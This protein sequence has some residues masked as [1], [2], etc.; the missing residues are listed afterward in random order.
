MRKLHKAS[1]S[2]FVL[3][4]LGCGQEGTSPQ[5]ENGVLD[6][7]NY[8]WSAGP[9]SLKGVWRFYWKEFVDPQAQAPV[10]GFIIVPG[11]WNQFATP[12]GEAGGPGY[13]TYRLEVKLGQQPPPLSLRMLH[14]DS[15]CRIYVNGMLVEQI[16][17]PGKSANENIAE[18]K[19]GVIRLE[20]A[21]NLDIV[22]HVANFEHRNGGFPRD[23]LIGPTTQ[24]ENVRLRHLFRDLFLCGSLCMM[25]LYHFALF[26]LRP[27]D[28]AP[29]FFALFCTLIAIR[30][31]LVG[32]RV[33]SY[34]LF[35]SPSFPLLHRIEYLSFL[36]ATPCFFAYAASLF[37]GKVFR[38]WLL[39]TISA[40]FIAGSAVVI[41]T[42]SF[43]YTQ[44][45]FAFQIL[46]MAV[47]LYI[48]G[49]AVYLIHL[50]R[51]GARVFVGTFVVFFLSVINDVLYS[52]SVV[53]SGFFV[54]LGLFLFT[55][56][57]AFLLSRLY[58]ESF[59]RVEEL[60]IDLENSE[61]RYRHLVEDSGEIILSLDDNGI[62]LSSNQAATRILGYSL[63]D[64]NG[65]KLS[66]LIYDSGPS[67][68]FM[69]KRLFEERLVELVKNDK[70][71]E[72]PAHFRTTHSDVCELNVRLQRVTLENG[73]AIIANLAQ[74][75]MDI[76][77]RYCLED[78]RH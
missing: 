64:L 49:G 69:A 7:R 18:R 47:G 27:R 70:S 21:E 22:I 59:R 37:P 61:R 72:F 23:L 31:D 38:P 77:A 55:F 12:A 13:A 4:I 15:A 63:K 53:N 41:T 20:P 26:A 58:A 71:Q 14:F 9:L 5:A 78:H 67:N 48:M 1:L 19:P 51:P 34:L 11:K 25:A 33:I 54:A 57:Q 42:P 43:V 68:A 60:A 24:I 52:R 74:K 73:R 29:L 36:L 30:S 17:N 40:I 3:L 56:T 66:S 65:L 45:L 50:K 2:L 16:G 35:S 8:S 76:L 28:R 75:P 6:L 10:S 46:M 32:E 44:T 62:I 39:N